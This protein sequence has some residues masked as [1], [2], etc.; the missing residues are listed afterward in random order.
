MNNGKMRAIFL[1][2]VLLLVS[3]ASSGIHT[4]LAQTEQD[5]PT[6]NSSAWFKLENSERQSI[7]IGDVVAQGQINPDGSCIGSTFE[8][9]MEGDVKSVSV[10][11]Q[12]NTCS[13]VVKDIVLNSGVDERD[14]PIAGE[15]GKLDL[16]STAQ[17]SSEYTWRVHST[18]EWRGAGNEE[19][20]QTI[21]SVTFKTASQYGGGAVYGGSQP[22][23]SCYAN[24]SAP[25]FWWE[26]DA[27]RMVEYSLTGPDFIWAKSSG[28]FSHD[29]FDWDHELTAK[30]EGRGWLPHPEIFRST[31][32]SIGTVPW[33]AHFECDLDWEVIW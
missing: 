8:I 15:G 18:S 33:P 3:A 4:V 20:T 25:I 28:E 30:A 1:F 10:G 12:E 13:L 5:P 17:S 6:Q 32:R 19:L 31:C 9:G 14:A 2:T 26:V 27:C 7:S 22:S 11:I 24:H 21:A 23:Y 16:R 29:Y